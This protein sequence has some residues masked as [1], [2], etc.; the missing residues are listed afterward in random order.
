[1]SDE[2]VIRHGSPT[3][4]GLKTGNLFSCT[5]PGKT[6]LQKAFAV[7]KSQIGFK[8]GPYHS[9]ARDGKNSPSLFIQ[10][11]KTERG[12]CCQRGG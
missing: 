9:F 1:M 5:Y 6:Q 11:R 10:T 3:L 7:V 4:A 2:M 8:R 12:F